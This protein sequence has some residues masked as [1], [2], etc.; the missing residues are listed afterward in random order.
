MATIVTQ[1][2]DGQLSGLEINNVVVSP[3]VQKLTFPGKWINNDVTAFGSVGRRY[4]P[5][6]D[7]T[8]FTIELLWNQVATNGSQT[9]VGNVFNSKNTVAFS[10]FPAGNSNGQLKINGLCSIPEYDITA[11]VGTYVKAVAV[12]YV[13]NGVTFSTI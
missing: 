5:G 1:S 3:S 4:A 11:Q 13:D 8:K 10:F 12:C 2:I 7:E 6:I 9:V